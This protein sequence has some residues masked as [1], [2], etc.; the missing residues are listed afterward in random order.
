MANKDF[1]GA[2]ILFEYEADY[3][4]VCFHCQQTIEK[5]FKGYLLYQTGVL[6]EGHGLIKLCK[7]A[8]EFDV[9]FKNFIKDCA[10]VNAYYIETR[11]PSEDPLN[12]TEEEVVMC[13]DIT[14]RIMSLVDNS[15]RNEK[16]TAFQEF[17]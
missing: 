17:E 15:I 8:T 10:F 13:L 6:Q 5:Y 9:Q 1:R 2:E 16:E 12:I 11:Y 3:G 14:K 4:L 7:K